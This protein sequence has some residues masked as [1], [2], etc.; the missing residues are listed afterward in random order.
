MSAQSSDAGMTSVALD[1]LEVGRLTWIGLTLAGIGWAA[2][3]GEATVADILTVKAARPLPATFHADLI[4]I[5]KCII[6]SG[7]GLAVIGAL[8]SGFGTLNRFFNAVL[9]RSAQRFTPQP[10]S[11]SIVVDATAAPARDRRPYRT[12]AD[13]SIEVETI[14]GTR[15]FATMREAREFI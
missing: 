6:A 14:V 5:A 12:L 11:E 15:R 2:L 7:F 13:G 4:D 10:Q 8:Q 1:A 3:I 9:A